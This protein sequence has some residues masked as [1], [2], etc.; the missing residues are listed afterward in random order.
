MPSDVK[1]SC[2]H[3]IGR[4]TGFTVWAATT[5]TMGWDWTFFT[6]RSK[7]SYFIVLKSCFEM[8]QLKLMGRPYHKKLVNKAMS[9]PVGHLEVRL[10][11]LSS[12]LENGLK[13]ATLSDWDGGEPRTWTTLLLYE[14]GRLGLFSNR[15]WWQQ[16]EDRWFPQNEGVYTWSNL[17]QTRRSLIQHP[18]PTSTMSVSWWSP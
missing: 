2:Y 16:Q 4:C 11:I 14:A 9:V 10:V 1:V 15:I 5:G 3:L 8:M 7:K 6:A 17:F 18:A 12:K 13:A